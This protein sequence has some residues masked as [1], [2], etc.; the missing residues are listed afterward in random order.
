MIHYH[1]SYIVYNPH[2]TKIYSL[3]DILDKSQKFLNDKIFKIDS[4]KV[5]ND[6][7]PNFNYVHLK[8]KKIKSNEEDQSKTRI[9]I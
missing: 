4:K 9:L 3:I 8:V 5:K 2:T 1:T 6:A 7:D